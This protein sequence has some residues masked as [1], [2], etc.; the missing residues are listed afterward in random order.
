LLYKGKWDAYESHPGGV[1]IEK[2]GGIW[3]NGTK[4]LYKGK[5]DAYEA[6]IKGVL[7]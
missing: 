7:I 6:N 2:Y 3:L 5:W 4:L 1:L